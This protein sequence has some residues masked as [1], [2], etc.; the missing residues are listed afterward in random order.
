MS[1][2]HA[3]TV[4]G[5]VAAAVL[6]AA[7]GGS[8]AQEALSAKLDASGMIQVSR[9]GVELAMIELNAHGP[10]WQHAPQASATGEVG[11]LPDGTGKQ[12]IGTLPIPN[13]DGGAIRFTESVESLPQGLHLE[14]DLS[15]AAAM[16]LNGL[17]L[18]ICLPVTG[19]AGKELAIP[20]ADGEL[21][22]VGL[23]EEQR[24][25]F[26]L[27]SGE[28]AKIEVAK[29]TDEAVTVEL[30]AAADVIVQ[31]LRQWERPIFEIRFPAI[32]EQE[33]REVAADDKFHL[34]L[35]VTFASPLELEGP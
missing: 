10:N 18:S 3:R 27:W 33:G 31:D 29:D 24:Q 21:Q 9:G 32:M 19:Y 15:M 35:T 11:D 28:G 12:V 4:V 13:T 8:W 30:R 20:K 7:A 2:L 26:Q 6:L 16:R 25:N 17:Q 14:Y 23:P 34:D 5:S 22:I 1:R